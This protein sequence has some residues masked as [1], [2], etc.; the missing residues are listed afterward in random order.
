MFPSYEKF[1][2][3]AHNFNVFFATTVAVIVSVFIGTL[4]A[5]WNFFNQPITVAV[6]IALVAIPLVV[7]INTSLNSEL[8]TS[9][10]TAWC[11]RIAGRFDQN[12]ILKQ[13]AHQYKIPNW[14]SK[15]QEVEVDG[16]WN[17]HAETNYMHRL[18]DQRDLL[19]SQIHQDFTKQETVQKQIIIEAHRA[20]VD[21]SIV[22]EEAKQKENDFRGLI[23]KAKSPG[24]TFRQRRRLE[25]ATEDRK[26]KEQAVNDERHYLRSLEQNLEKLRDDYNSV[27]YRVCKIY[28]QRYVRYTEYAI[29][30]I[31]KINGLRYSI[32]DLPSPEK[33]T[34]A[35]K[36]KES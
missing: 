20:I 30:K 34:K 11:D 16:R 8:R 14:R 7:Y 6:F 18:A 2:K 10:F 32:V 9:Y 27:V 1:V 31:N 15:L 23:N 3:C 21:R 13:F 33:W 25:V 19:L 12:K 24:E 26:A 17:F 35:S 22:Y 36:R 5:S 28:Y 29:K 4:L